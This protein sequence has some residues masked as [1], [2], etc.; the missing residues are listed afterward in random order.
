VWP[1]LRGLT[2]GGVPVIPSQPKSLRSVSASA[3]RYRWNARPDHM[4][5]TH[6]SSWTQSTSRSRLYRTLAAPARAARR[7]RSAI[8]RRLAQGKSSRRRAPPR[9]ASVCALARIDETGLPCRAPQS[10]LGA[11][12][13]Q[14]R[15]EHRSPAVRASTGPTCAD[16][17]CAHLEMQAASTYAS[18]NGACE[19][20]GKISAPVEQANSASRAAPPVLAAPKR[21]LNAHRP[22][23]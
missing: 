4:G 18:L 3:N 10:P 17:E 19:G 13:W 7:R 16:S 22:T 2:N 14:I 1:T 11:S 15:S 8:P 6:R 5:A 23:P 20:P 21:Q 12:A 9:P